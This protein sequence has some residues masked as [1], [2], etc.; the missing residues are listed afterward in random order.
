MRVLLILFALFGFTFAS[1]IGKISS[2]RGDVMISR[3]NQNIKAYVGQALKKKDTILTKKHSS[4]Q[5]IFK[6]DTSVNVGFDSSFSIE[7][8]LVDNADNSQVALRAN[9]GAI[10]V[11]TGRIGKIAPKRFK[12]STKTSTIGIRGTNFMV[13]SK[14]L[15][16]QIYCLHG[17][18][19]VDSNIGKAFVKA[20]YYVDVTPK[21][22]KLAPKQ[23][24]PSKVKGIVE[25]KFRAY[26]SDTT[27]AHVNSLSS[28]DKSAKSSGKSDDLIY[29]VGSGKNSSDN[30]DDK[31]KNAENVKS[32][33]KNNVVDLGRLSKNKDAI[34]KPKDNIKEP[35]VIDKPSVEVDEKKDPLEPINE[36]KPDVVDVV[37]VDTE[38][39]FIS[40]GQVATYSTKGQKIDGKYISA[41]TK[42]EKS[43]NDINSKYEYIDMTFDFGAKGKSGK[44]LKKMDGY[45]G[46]GVETSYVKV[47][48]TN[49]VKFNKDNLKFDGDYSKGGKLSGEFSSKQAELIKNGA[50]TKINNSNEKLLD[51]KFEAK[52]Q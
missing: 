14:G 11:I 4:A 15:D 49:N 52:K 23:F 41:S 10:R 13:L 32:D 29:A 8:Y 33:I 9:R 1:V 42:E 3:D 12:L 5:I 39:D 37:H 16:E 44:F 47:D 18:I 19:T 36:S 30:A 20:G 21:V 43:L 31:I 22:L 50:I 48:E 35:I 28:Q 46:N 51:V 2:I 6:D 27:D 45:L 34:K 38:D 17:A 7:E 25:E 40:K 26:N 24:T